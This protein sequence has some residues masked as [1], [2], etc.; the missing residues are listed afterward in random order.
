MSSLQTPLRNLSI[1]L[2]FGLVARGLRIFHRYR[3]RVRLI[4]MIA[5]E[6]L[7]KIMASAG[8]AVES[9]LCMHHQQFGIIQDNG[10]LSPLLDPFV[11]IIAINIK[12]PTLAL[13]RTITGFIRGGIGIL[14]SGLAILH[15]WREHAG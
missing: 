7:G 10:C 3:I 15:L 8:D 12:F 4:L 13:P 2:R 5:T 11:S 9:S 1:F 6:N 14:V